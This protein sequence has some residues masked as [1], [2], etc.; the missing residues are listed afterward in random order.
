MAQTIFS[1]AAHV[2]VEGLDT[3]KILERRPELTTYTVTGFDAPVIVQD[4]RPVGRAQIRP[5]SPSTH[6]RMQT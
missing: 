6:S 4:Y 2:E 1:R 5:K 3:L